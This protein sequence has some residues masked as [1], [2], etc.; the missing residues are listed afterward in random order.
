MYGEGM[1]THPVMAAVWAVLVGWAF[2]L[3]RADREMIWLF[4]GIVLLNVL[5]AGRYDRT[6]W[7]SEAQP[8]M[9]VL[10]FLAV[11]S[12]L[13]LADQLGRTLRWW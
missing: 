6:L 10:G 2:W 4:A 1:K 12:L 9:W 11:L 5:I 3:G 13:L 8:L 7:T